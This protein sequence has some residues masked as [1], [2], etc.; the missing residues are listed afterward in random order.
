[1]RAETPAAQGGVQVFGGEPF[2]ASDDILQGGTGADRFRFELTLN[3]R[4][5]IVAK[6]V[7]ADGTIDWAGGHRREQC[8]ATITG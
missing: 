6:H 3:G 5:E 1:M 2:N 8:R 4:E 7:N